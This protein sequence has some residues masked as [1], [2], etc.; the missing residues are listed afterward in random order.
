V[1]TTAG[2]HRVC[3]APMMDRTDRHFRYL[4]RRIAPRTYLY[5]EMITAAAIVRGNADALLEF[6]PSEHPVAIQ[7]GGSSPAELRT[8]ARRAEDA[9]YDE[10]NLNVGCPSDRVQAGCFGAAMMLQPDLVAECVAAM[11]DA[12]S[13][14]VTVKTRLGVDRHD[15]YEFLRTLVAAVV[16]AGCGTLIVHA[17]KAWLSGLSPKQNREI[18]PLDYA[19][20]DRV[21]DDFPDLEVVLNGGLRTI[22]AVRS[23]LARL[24]GVMLGRLAYDRPLFLREV[25][26]VAFGSRPVSG[27]ADVLAAWI[28]YASAQ[29]AA[30][31]P[32]K[33]MT[34]HLAGL[35]AGTPGARSW[36]REL[37]SLPEGIQGLVRL[38]E[39]VEEMTN[40][41][42]SQNDS[43][44][45]LLSVAD[46]SYNV[47]E[48][49]TG[50]P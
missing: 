32:L 38:R 1:V 26:A 48:S 4:L 30:G 5:T 23:G 39:L 44:D 47:A 35:F 22:E 8:A 34:R 37:G 33:R 27:T 9:G 14:P 29:T 19:R 46:N 15:D 10:V 40:S 25:E 28:D 11:N 16:G 3:L 13:I 18:P 7:L 20:V 12:V 45:T 36:R 42:H 50:P 31:V 2:S 6:D 24:D 41:S 49:E 17:R 43:T 21:K